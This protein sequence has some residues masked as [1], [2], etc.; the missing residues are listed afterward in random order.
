MYEE[1]GAYPG[2]SLVRAA[3]STIDTNKMREVVG[4]ATGNKMWL[5]VQIMD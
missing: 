5:R 2:A 3:D 4:M 1:N